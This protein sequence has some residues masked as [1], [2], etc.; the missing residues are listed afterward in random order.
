MSAYVIYC[1]CV[2]DC[3]HISFAILTKLFSFTNELRG[4]ILLGEPPILR[5]IENTSIIIEND[6][7]YSLRKERAQLHRQRQRVKR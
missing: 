7:K 5:S 3:S 4:Y 1:Y 2:N 6:T